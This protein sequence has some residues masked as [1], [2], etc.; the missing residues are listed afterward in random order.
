MGAGLRAE[1]ASGERYEDY[2]GRWSRAVAGEFLAWLQAPP[3]LAWL[4]V[5]CGTGALAGA[6]AERCSPVLLEGVDPSA[7]FLEMARERVPQGAFRQ[8]D[9]QALPHPAASFERVVSGL[10]LSF[11]PDP[12]RAVAEMARVARPGGEVALYVWDYAERMELMRRFWD[13]AAALASD[14]GTADEARRS[15]ICRPEPLRALLKGAGLAAVETRAIEVPTV[16]RDFED[17]WRPFLGG[18]GTAP[19]WCMRLSEEMRERL[20]L[21]LETDLPREADGS[22]RLVARAWAARGRR[23]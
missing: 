9:A 5:G 10:V 7:G 13:A 1:W 23:E 20:R 6:V 21:R 15:P 2:M 12:A 11:V 19:A 4:D 3:G 8:G 16:F 18:Q 17:Y 14:R 22:I